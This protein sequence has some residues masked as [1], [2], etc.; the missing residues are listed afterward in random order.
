MLKY[1]KR[2]LILFQS[3]RLIVYAHFKFF[4]IYTNVEIFFIIPQLMFVIARIYI[5]ARKLFYVKMQMYD[6]MKLVI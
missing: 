4:I 3:L 2:F 5:H 1:I 6:A